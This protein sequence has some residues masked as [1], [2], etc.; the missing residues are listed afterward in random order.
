M[1]K[2]KVEVRSN[3]SIW[4]VSESGLTTCAFNLFQFQYGKW[5]IEINVKQNNKDQEFEDILLIQITNNG[6]NLFINNQE[7]TDTATIENDHYSIYTEK[8]AEE[9]ELT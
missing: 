8:Y 6:K 7:I 1:M 4:L 3:G 9:L 5:F 2:F